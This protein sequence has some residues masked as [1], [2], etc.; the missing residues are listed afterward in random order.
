[1]EAARKARQDLKT[2]GNE[3]FKQ[4][5]WDTA[6][7]IYTK[8]IE[9]LPLSTKGVTMEDKALQAV[10]LS[11]RAMCFLKL[12]TPLYRFAFTST[13]ATTPPLRHPATT[14]PQPCRQPYPLLM[15]RTLLQACHR[16]L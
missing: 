16:G 12:E 5:Q 3:A 13:I 7:Q 14:R 10:L 4:S 2:E 11:N 9:A 6:A 1:M 15:P 8:A